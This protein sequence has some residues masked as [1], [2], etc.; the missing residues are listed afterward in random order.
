[1]VRQAWH[2]ISP[3]HPND[4]RA[5]VDQAAEIGPPLTISRQNRGSQESRH[6]RANLHVSASR[7]ALDQHALYSP[8]PSQL[9]QCFR[10][11]HWWQLEPIRDHP[12]SRHWPHFQRGR[13]RVK[14]CTCNKVAVKTRWHTYCHR[15]GE[16]VDITTK[17]ILKPSSPPPIAK[18]SLA[19]TCMSPSE[20]VPIGSTISSG[21]NWDSLLF[22]FFQKH[23]RLRSHFTIFWHIYMSRT[24]GVLRIQRFQHRYT[25]P[26]LLEALSRY[27]LLS[28]QISSRREKCLR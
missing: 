10:Q 22:L 13:W 8:R 11:L 16:W 14:C 23:K 1:M 26:G 18:R 6:S 20:S 4:P 24:R 3:V 5:S 15:H 2:S 12:N 21:S 9:P 28:H 25:F 7:I 17:E 27:V 19:S